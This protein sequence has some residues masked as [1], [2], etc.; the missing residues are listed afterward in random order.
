MKKISKYLFLVAI[1]ALMAFCVTGCTIPQQQKTHVCLYDEFNI[2]QLGE[3][4]QTDEHDFII[5]SKPAIPDQTDESGNVI[6]PGQEGGVW[7]KDYPED[8]PFV[9][10][11]AMCYDLELTTTITLGQNVYVG[12][13]T[14]SAKL[15]FNGGEVIV[16]EN[17]GFYL[18]D[19]E[20]HGCY[21]SMEVAQGLSSNYLDFAYAYAKKNNQ[22][23]F[24]LDAGNYSLNEPFKLTEYLESGKIR[25]EDPA[26]TVICLNNFANDESWKNE[27]YELYTYGFRRVYR[28][29]DEFT[30]S[31]QKHICT[32]ML[33]ELNSLALNQYNLEEIAQV[34]FSHENSS[35][36]L[37]NYIFLHLTSDVTFSGEIQLPKGL[38]IGVCKNGY[39]F[40]VNK[41]EGIYVFDCKE[42]VCLGETI[43][44]AKPIYKEG[45]QIMSSY[46]A[47]LHK[48][49]SSYP[50]SIVISEGTYALMDNFDAGE[51]PESIVFSENVQLC[52]NG[53]SIV[54]NTN[55]YEDGYTWDCSGLENY[56][57]HTCKE[58]SEHGKAIILKQSTVES[59]ML[60][61]VLQTKGDVVICLG[62][63]FVL[64]ET[65]VVPQGV[66]LHIC[67]NGN[68]LISAQSLQES[69]TPYMFYVEFG[70]SLNI[71]DCSENHTGSLVALTEDMMM[72]EERTYNVSATPIYNMGTCTVN[73]VSL[74]GSFGLE[75]YGHVVAINSQISGLTVGIYNGSV[76]KDKFPLHSD[77][78][79]LTV[80]GGEVTSLL[81]GVLSSSGDLA[82]SDCQINALQ[83]GIVQT[84]IDVLSGTLPSSGDLIIDNV[85][86]SMSTDLLGERK[87]A[88]MA[89]QIR[90]TLG[91]SVIGVISTGDILVEGDMQVT[92]DPFLL[93]SFVDDSGELVE[94]QSVDFVLGNAQFDV[95]DG[96]K[97]SEQYSVY[98][99]LQ[100]GGTQVLANKDMSENL[101]LVGG[102]ASVTN[103]DGEMVVVAGDDALFMKSA[104]VYD[105]SVSM[106][107]YVRLELI[108]T[109]DTVADYLFTPNA[110]SRVIVSIGGEQKELIP[111]EL[112]VGDKYVYSIDLY[113]H[114]YAN[115]INIQFTNGTYTWTGIANVSIESMLIS[116]L[117]EIEYDLE[118]ERAILEDGNASEEEKEKAKKNFEEANAIKNAVVAMINY[119]ETA[120]VHFE[121]KDTYE[122]RDEIFSFVMTDSKVDETTGEETIVETPIEISIEDAMNLVTP[123]MIEYA[124]LSV[125]ESAVMPKGVH[126]LGASVV[127]DSG[128][129]IRFYFSLAKDRDLSTLVF[130]IDGAEATPVSYG[131]SGNVYYLEIEDISAF[132]ISYM[133]S[134][135]IADKAEEVLEGETSQ[136]INTYSFKYGVLSYMY[137]VLSNENSSQELVNVAK[138]TCIYSLFMNKAMETISGNSQTETSEN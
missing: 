101:L 132:K 64:P 128:L 34:I 25:F 69:D 107:G 91:G 75:N 105:A 50:S 72:A 124:K 29:C 130:T 38:K 13:C 138:A 20:A 111:S 122:P 119:C 1:I 10:A 55:A 135:V 112:K 12:I 96:V 28:E 85:T 49:D 76:D 47:D 32:Y 59:I 61:N 30:A 80:K 54:N 9:G 110:S 21:A 40:N 127:L 5:M 93:E 73:G 41:V 99:L 131:E 87:T 65:I 4:Y 137:T 24:T 6:T 58:L 120:A 71:V 43:K 15:T 94:P 48:L 77:N 8:D 2:T 7:T 82:L 62:E 70:A 104:V 81:C 125:S 90:A 11:Y 39:E 102:M 68:S 53:H 89:E 42:H 46:L 134:V 118:N 129:D 31:H 115:E 95:A 79:T 88:E 97:L 83:V 18:Y 92:I 60:S 57:T 100:E 109:F 136:Q 17:S 45:I 51:W 114:D 106:Q 56:P 14:H 37:D 98:C 52:R 113:A 74:I 66:S 26:N 117:G 23:C 126:F 86:I 35:N 44:V 36:P 67:L 103:A 84:D 63:D 121:T 116:V 27:I 16:P 133:Y 19:C 123:S 3:L 33:D 78:P 108:F 22:T